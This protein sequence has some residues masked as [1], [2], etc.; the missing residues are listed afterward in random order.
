MEARTP[1]GSATSQPMATPSPAPSGAPA[2]TLFKYVD[3]VL[4][5]HLVPRALV[6]GERPR[7]DLA[8]PPEG[9]DSLAG[10]PELVV[11]YGTI[12]GDDVPLRDGEDIPVAIATGHAGTVFGRALVRVASSAPGAGATRRAVTAWVDARSRAAFGAALWPQSAG[13]D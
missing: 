1:A 11:I 2:S 4:G 8:A 13:S 3:V 10:A 7:S 6:L 9:G 5:E 12:V